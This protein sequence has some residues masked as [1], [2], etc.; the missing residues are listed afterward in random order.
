[1]KYSEIE[2][3]ILHIYN[4]D[5]RL[6]K[7]IEISRP[8]TIKP[9]KNYYDLLLRS[10]VQQQLSINAAASIH[11]KFMLYFDNKPLPEKII[12]TPHEILRGLG[13]S[14]AKVKYVK[15]LSEK[16]MEREISFRGMNK[17]SDEEII[18]RLTR[19]KGIGVWTSH[20]FLIFTLGRLNV[21]PIGDLGLRR[22]IK[23]V[24]GLIRLPDEK[25]I[26]KIS[27]ENGWH[28]YNSI[29]S[30]YLWRSLELES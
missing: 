27:K 9:K 7:I 1:M 14:N 10:I 11:K 28:P 18:A 17:K 26:I 4:N 12:N 3:G 30:W 13:L 23:N 22:A 16:I 21:L 15:D 2:N 24:Y 29:A 8:C 5:K 25:K 20:M 19:V 6:A